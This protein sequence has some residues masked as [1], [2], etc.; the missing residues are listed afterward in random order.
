MRRGH[1]LMA[2]AGAGARMLGQEASTSTGSLATRAVFSLMFIGFGAA[3]G[4]AFGYQKA[5]ADAGVL[6]RGRDADD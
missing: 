3:L 4:F 5:V 6:R 2:A 1:P